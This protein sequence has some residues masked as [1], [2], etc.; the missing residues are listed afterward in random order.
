MATIPISM[1]RI[2]FTSVKK[3]LLTVITSVPA[4]ISFMPVLSFK[5]FETS[6]LNESSFGRKSV[7][8]GKI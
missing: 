5:I 8:G 3:T 7:F 1:S 2:K 4:L 6:N